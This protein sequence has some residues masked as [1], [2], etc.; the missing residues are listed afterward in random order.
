MTILW[1]IVATVSV[2]LNLIVGILYLSERLR[3]VSV[4][5]KWLRLEKSNIGN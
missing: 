4:R 2:I 3:Y 1:S 5:P